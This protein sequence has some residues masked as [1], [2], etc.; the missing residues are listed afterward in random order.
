MHAI[1]DP[2]VNRFRTIRAAGGAVILAGLL[3]GLAAIGAQAPERQYM[4]LNCAYDPAATGTLSDAVS[5]IPAACAPAATATAA[6]APDEERPGAH[7][8]PD[9]SAVD[10]PAASANHQPPTF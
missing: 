8:V 6:V 9:A 3:A 10:F 5:E 4:T 1:E 7:R 2:E